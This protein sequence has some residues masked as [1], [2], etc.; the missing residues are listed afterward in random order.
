MFTINELIMYL[1]IMKD[2]GEAVRVGV[3]NRTVSIG[4]MKV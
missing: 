3:T 1:D 2:G 4:V